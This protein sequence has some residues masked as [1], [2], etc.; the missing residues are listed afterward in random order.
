MLTWSPVTHSYKSTSF[1]GNWCRVVYRTFSHVCVFVGVHFGGMSF[2]R[3]SIELGNEI[4]L[5]LL[6]KGH[7]RKCSCYNRPYV[8]SHRGLA[9][10]LFRIIG[11]NCLP[12]CCGHAHD[13]TQWHGNSS[14]PRTH[15]GKAHTA[16][17]VQLLSPTLR[18]QQ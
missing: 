9:V 13:H 1:V 14:V 5:R 12:H 6:A 18:H 17:N 10:R 2:V 8:D 7:V 11:L 4:P 16:A 3:Y 15:K